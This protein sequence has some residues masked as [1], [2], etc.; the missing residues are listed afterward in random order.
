[1]R[2]E[3][4][5]LMVAGAFFSGALDFNTPRRQEVLLIGLGGGVINNYLTAMPNHSV[6][7]PCTNSCGY[8]YKVLN[9]AISPFSQ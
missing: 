9:C 3:Y 4:A 5:R 1:M 2:L 7:T 8:I 6:S